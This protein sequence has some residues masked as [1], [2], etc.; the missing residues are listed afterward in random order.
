[1]RKPRPWDYALRITHYAWKD[2]P[3]DDRTNRPA[4]SVPHTSVSQHDWSLHR[5][6]PMDQQRHK[7]RI[8]EA[9]KQNLP[10]IVSEE[11]IILS[12]G[13]HV[14][15]VPIR[16]LEEYRFKYNDNDG[17][18]TGSG[19]GDSQVGDVIGRA[20]GSQGP[21]KGK[22]EAGEEP[23]VDYYEAEVSVDEIAA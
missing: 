13:K 16:S 18:H 5:K 17:Q 6:G 8:K 7:E 21:G 11:N 2:K 10:N 20:G 4:G 22:G 23:G 3:M 15:K 9:I 19:D 12:D 1:M 14:I